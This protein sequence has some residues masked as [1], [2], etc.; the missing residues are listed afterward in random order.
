MSNIETVVE[1]PRQQKAVHAAMEECAKA[2][3]VLR[4]TVN[5]FWG[6]L[7]AVLAESSEDCPRD[8]KQIGK[9]CSLAD[10]IDDFTYDI[11]DA[12]SML[13]RIQKH[14]QV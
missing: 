11:R 10:G 2:I 6:E 8:E 13:N 12:A 1:S 4:S 9:V 14:L 7:S 3:S 5:D